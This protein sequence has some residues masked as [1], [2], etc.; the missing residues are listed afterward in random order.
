[1]FCGAIL[2]WQ[3]EAMV[4]SYLSA[5]TIVL[6]FKDLSGL[7]KTDFRIAATPGIENG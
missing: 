5:R 6:P 1:L 7:L 2:F 3:W 4:T